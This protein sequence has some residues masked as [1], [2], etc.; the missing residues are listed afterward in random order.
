MIEQGRQPILEQRQPVFH[1]RKPPPFA[2]RFVKRVLR[3][4]GAEQLAIAGAEAL[5]A[6]LVQQRLA[7]GQEQMPVEPPRRQLGVG[8]ETAQAFQLVTEEIEP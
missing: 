4:I 1:T 6:V 3:G 2:D 5:D 8:I 7:G